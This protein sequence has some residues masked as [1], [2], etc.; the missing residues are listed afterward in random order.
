MGVSYFH[1]I[2][3]LCEGD[4]SSFTLPERI[5][6]TPVYD[7]ETDGNIVSFTSGGYGLFDLFTSDFPL[8]DNW[9]KVSHRMS[10]CQGQDWDVVD[11]V[12]KDE[13]VSLYEDV[14]KDENGEY[15]YEPG[16]EYTD[17]TSDYLPASTIRGLMRPRIPFYLFL[18]AMALGVFL[19]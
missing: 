15:E 8:P 12:S 19:L 11:W 4:V 6:N 13:I 7:L 2:K 3:V 9:V 10:G 1:T 5:N 17:P 16:Y 14:D 18:L